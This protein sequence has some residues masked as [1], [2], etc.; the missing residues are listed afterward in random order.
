MYTLPE[1]LEFEIAKPRGRGKPLTHPVDRLRTRLWF[2]VI[3][4]RSGLSSGY[5]VEAF[6]DGDRLK[7]DEAK[8]I[9][10]KRWSKYQKGLR[11]P[12]D[13]LGHRNAID[14]AESHFPGTA[15]WFRSPIWPVLRGEKCDRFF[16]EKGLRQL[17]SEVRRV[18]F[19]DAALEQ[20]SPVPQKPFGVESKEELFAIGSFDALVAAVLLIALSEDIASPELRELALNLYLSLQSKLKG[21]PELVPFYPELFSMIDSRCKHWVYLSPNERLD[22]VVFW[23]AVPDKISQ[24]SLSIAEKG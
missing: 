2:H 1:N 12:D 13:R 10:P 24:L 7:K 16:V 4:L 8:I 20:R 19:E 3:K 21:L 18:F 9:R 6:L 11:V 14:Q 5:A 17:S 15:Q 22:M 23:Q